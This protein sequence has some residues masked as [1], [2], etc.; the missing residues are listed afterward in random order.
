MGTPAQ[1]DATSVPKEMTLSVPANDK[2]SFRTRGNTPGDD[3]PN[4]GK[5]RA[6]LGHGEALL[7]PLHKGV[8]ERGHGRR[9]DEAKRA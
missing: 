1:R 6:A 5:I 2:E 8:K 9:D 4:H 7:Q 3:L